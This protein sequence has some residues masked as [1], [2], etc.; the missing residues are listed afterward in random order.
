MVKTCLKN[1]ADLDHLVWFLSSVF[2]V[3]L[4]SVVDV[5]IVIGTSNADLQRAT[6]YSMNVQP[7][8]TTFYNS[9]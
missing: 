3:S 4:S 9:R 6:R 2:Y 7:I 8:V 1:V 5:L